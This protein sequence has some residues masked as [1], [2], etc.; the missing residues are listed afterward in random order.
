[1]HKGEPIQKERTLKIESQKYYCL[2]TSLIL[3][4]SQNLLDILRSK[5]NQKH[6]LTIKLPAKPCFFWS[7]CF[8]RSPLLIGLGLSIIKLKRTGTAQILR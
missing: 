8:S 2:S 6:Q 4:N 7:Q 3:I 1:M 5:S